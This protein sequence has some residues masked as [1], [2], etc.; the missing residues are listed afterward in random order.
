MLKV[1]V[2]HMQGNGGGN[3]CLKVIEDD[4]TRFGKTLGFI[5]PIQYN[6]EGYWGGTTYLTF[7]FN[8]NKT[9][10]TEQSFNTLYDVAKHLGV[11]DEE[12]GNAIPRK[13]GPYF[14]QWEYMNTDFA[15]DL[16]WK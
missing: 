6:L 5:I 12:L 8:E 14:Y 16:W 15:R 11:N 13:E 4:G 1:T 7:S 9:G 10:P 2:E 3:H